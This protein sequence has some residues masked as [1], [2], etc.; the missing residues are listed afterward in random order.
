MGITTQ[1]VETHWNY[2][3]SIENDLEILSRYVELDKK[4]FGC[5]SMEI[6][7]ILLASSAEIDVVCKQLC[8]KIKAASTARNI[9]QYRNEITAEYKN[10]HRFKVLIPRYGLELK[11]WIRWKNPNNIPF[12]WTAHN[13]VKHHR[14]SEYYRANLRHALNSIA[15]LFVILLYFYREKAE[16]GELVP[17]PK[18]LR[19]AN[20][21]FRGI[22]HGGH[23][24][25]F[26]YQ[27]Q[28]H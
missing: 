24:L 27:L 13:K 17:N 25:G 4:N 9:N 22:T 5:F 7:R 8:L 15:A 28:N 18:L 16:L 21:H 2:L 19:V 10:I 14:D 12:W 3:L 26:V 20:G 1:K 11:P 6:A 23:E